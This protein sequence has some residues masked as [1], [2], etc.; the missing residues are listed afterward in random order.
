MRGFF[1]TL[2]RNR[3]PARH[4]E[5]GQVLIVV[6]GALVAIL[7]MV[8]LAVDLGYWRNQQRAEQS[9]ADSA[10][11]AGVIATYYPTTAASPAPTEVHDAAVASAAQ[12]GYPIAS[13]TTVDVHDPP[14]LGKFAGTAGYVEVTVTK[15]QPLFFS[16]IFGSSKPS[17]SARAVATQVPS[18]NSAC[19]TQYGQLAGIDLNSGHLVA[20]NCNVVANHP[21]DSTNCVTANAI[22]VYDISGGSPVPPPPTS[23]CSGDQSKV[24]AATTP[25]ADPCPRMPGCATLYNMTFPLLPPA[26][27]TP[28]SASLN[29]PS[30]PGYLYVSGGIT[31]ATD[32]GPGIYYIYGGIGAQITSSKGGV[33]IVNV[34]LPLAISGSKSIVSITAPST[35][36]TAGV[37]FYQPRTNLSPIDFKGA[38]AY[39]GGLFYAPNAYFTG[40]GS[41]DTYAALVIGGYSITGNKTLTIDPTTAPANVQ[42]LLKTTYATLAE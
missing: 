41:G 22:S 6:A 5:R 24:K 31:Q 4:G 3:H 36:P 1:P 13:G 20:V 9:A 39:W 34:D 19:L 2:G 25:A 37:A 42:P 21:I 14:A 23:I 28:D 16:G 17:V 8:A 11:L 30:N 29:A 32:F 12:N 7:A 26:N 18:A 27:A 33:T 15:V 38:S 35:G 40:H 10:A